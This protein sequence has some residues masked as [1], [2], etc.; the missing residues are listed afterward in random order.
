MRCRSGW[1]AAEG[2]SEDQ[3]AFGVAS[4]A[5]PFRF[6]SAFAVRREG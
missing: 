2:V 5:L 1:G 4:A 6:S 3:R